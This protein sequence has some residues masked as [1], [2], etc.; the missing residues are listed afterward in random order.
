MSTEAQEAIASD[1]ANP[2]AQTPAETQDNESQNPEADSDET[3]GQTSPDDESEEGDGEAPEISV[4]ER[5]SQ[6]EKDTESKQKAIDRKTAAYSALQKAHEKTLQELKAL[7]ESQVQAA[8]EE[9]EPVIDD[10]D[11]FEEYD[12]AR[13]EFLKA[14]AE[15]EVLQ[16]FQ[17]QQTAQKMQEIAQKRARI[18]QEQE[19]EYLKENP[20]YLHAK[21]EFEAFVQTSETHPEVEKAITET[22][23][24]GNVPQLINYFFGNNGENADKFEEIAHMNPI[25][26]AIEIYKTQQS[27]KAP[28]QKEKPPLPKPLNKPKGG[29]TPR[30][31][32]S[33]GDVLKNLGL[34]D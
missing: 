12:N 33:K 22:A 15:K 10:F 31:D 9:K 16:K 29:G 8:T 23:F 25:D 21:S 24:K 20:S 18:A 30:R 1:V 7:Q 28:A 13:A 19:A 11:T 5:L 14:K 6:L 17:E 32:L 27:L 26:A 2:H 3:E 34:K 4:E